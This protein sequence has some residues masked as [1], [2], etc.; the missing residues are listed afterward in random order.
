MEG[1]Y[2]NIPTFIL[3]EQCKAEIRKLEAQLEQQQLQVTLEMNLLALRS[4]TVTI[5]HLPQES[6]IIV[7]V[8]AKA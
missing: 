1:V 8:E 4:K 2:K 3:L 7:F 6:F 5:S